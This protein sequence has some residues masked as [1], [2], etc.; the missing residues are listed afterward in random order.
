MSFIA[1]PRPQPRIRSSRCRWSPCLRRG[2]ARRADHAAGGCRWLDRGRGRLCGRARPPPSGRSPILR[3]RGRGRPRTLRVRRC[4]S[5]G[6]FGIE[7]SIF[8]PRA[9]LTGGGSRLIA[10]AI[11]ICLPVPLLAATGLSVPLPNVVERI[12]AA[13]VPW[14]EPVAVETVAVRGTIVTTVAEKAPADLAAAGVA[15]AA[16]RRSVATPATPEARRAT[17]SSTSRSTGRAQARVAV[18]RSH[19]TYDFRRARGGTRLRPGRSSDRAHRRGTNGGGRRCARPDPFA[20]GAAAGL[21]A[22]C[23]AALGSRPGDAVSG[24]GSDAGS[25]DAVDRAGAS[26]SGS[27]P[28]ASYGRRGRRRGDDGRRRPCRHDRRRSC[29]HGRRHRPD[30]ARLCRRCCPG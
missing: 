9:P 6:H 22:C 7:H 24:T 14:A 3:R 16:V 8:V 30:T 25:V 1:G 28:G 2:A 23:S 21:G 12:A 20:R 27:A 17:A 13:L 5:C 10:V 29:R 15:P 19:D 26:G 11:G 18:G 4:L